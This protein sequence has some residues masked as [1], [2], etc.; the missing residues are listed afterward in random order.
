V[1]TAGDVA[2]DVPAKLP[3]RVPVPMFVPPVA[4]SPPAAT[5]EHRKNVTVPVGSCAG[6][7][8]TIVAVSVTDVPGATVPVLDAV[9]VI[10]A[11]QLPNWPR[12]KSFRVAVV[13]VDD[14][15]SDA[16]LEKHS[17]PSPRADRLT[18]PS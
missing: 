4:Q 16:T 13:D 3:A 9:V 1:L 15:V 6:L 2:V 17:S 5:P 8:P 10:V 14:R 18:P 7:L 12:T 11:V